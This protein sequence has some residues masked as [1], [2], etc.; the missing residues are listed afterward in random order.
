MKVENF[1]LVEHDA[2]RRG[3]HFDLRF[4]I[5]NSKN[6]VSFALKKFP[7]VKVGERA[8]MIKTTIH[9]RDNALF[10]GTIP[11]GEYG[12][13]TLTKI[14]GGTCDVIK[15]TNAHMIVNFHGK[16]LYGK[17]HIISTAIFG[18]KHDYTK[19]TYAV[20]KAKDGDTVSEGAESAKL[21]WREAISELK[22]TARSTVIGLTLVAMAPL[23]AKTMH[24]LI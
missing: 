13:G 24:Y 15:F 18:G 10:T 21:L 4:S 12:A 11:A 5:P 8:Y 20:F 23:I 1:I 17:Y 16:K 2:I 9:S 6:W 7:P 3:N 14:D 22:T 19:K